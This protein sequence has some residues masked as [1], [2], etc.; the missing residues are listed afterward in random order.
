M[1]API[2]GWQTGPSVGMEL[3][4]MG[5]IKEIQNKSSSSEKGSFKFKRK[6]GDS[7][8]KN[9]EDPDKDR[10]LSTNNEDMEDG[11]IIEELEDGQILE[12]QEPEQ[13]Q[14]SEVIKNLVQNEQEQKPLRW[15]LEK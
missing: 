1:K 3:F 14:S 8:S 15:Y 7:D 5:K 2:L 12:M 4:S 6:R 13:G 10:I 11:E 9:L